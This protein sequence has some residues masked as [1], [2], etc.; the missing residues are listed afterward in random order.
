MKARLGLAFATLALALSGCGTLLDDPASN[1]CSRD[2][3]CPTGRCDTTR[4]CVADPPSAMQ[5]ALMVV[6]AMDPLG[7]TPLPVT[8][9][10]TEVTGSGEQDLVLPLGVSVRGM[11]R[12]VL[13][14]DPASRGEPITAALTFSLVDGIHGVST[15]PVQ[16]Q[17]FTTPM[18]AGDEVFDYAV[19]LLPDRIY[20]VRVEPNGDWRSQLPPARFRYRTPAGGGGALPLLYP[21][22]T[23]TAIEGVVVD[24]SGDGQD[25]MLVRAIDSNDGRV[26]SSTYTT[27]SD[28]SHPQ[29][30]FSIQMPPTDDF[31][32]AIS[33]TS[34]R[35]AEGRPSPTFTVD[36][37]A[38]FDT[39]NG[40]A[41]LLPP[42]S[43]Q[44]I[45]YSGS[46]EPAG[47]PGHGTSATLTFTSTDVTDQT[48]GVVGTFR[49]T[50]ATD[51]YGA[52]SVQLLP[53]TYDLVVTPTDTETHNLG[54]LRVPRLML[55]TDHPTL[56]GQLYELPPRTHYGGNVQT[57]DARAMPNAEIHARPR[58]STDGGALADVAVYARATDTSTDPDGRFDLPLDVGLYDLTIQPPDGTEWPW[59]IVRNVAIGGADAVV[60]D[61]VE[62]SP[63]VPITGTVSFADG[64]AV[65]NGEVRAYAIIDESGTT[66]AV[67]IG[68]AQT[69]ADG[70]FTLLL[71]PSP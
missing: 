44:V 36:P 45:A 55:G 30:W 16:T 38:L 17:T 31:L 46:V 4:M 57:P 33:A 54:I 9:A 24:Q 11:V 34:S 28:T 68:R 18:T 8:F 42:I 1:T 52:F 67:Q 39:G 58:G 23:L 22:D 62:L 7:G 63:P 64:P 60:R 41:I 20:D 56:M 12:A 66:R 13:T 51:A 43:D 47:S 40:V 25:G 19:Q 71:P 48:T 69:N 3:D 37:G 61:V 50:V 6:P 26:I 59:S 35:L 70:A 27:G 15:P 65:A 5:V 32:I 29:G 53:G 10:P 49:A 14:G 21:V 2:S